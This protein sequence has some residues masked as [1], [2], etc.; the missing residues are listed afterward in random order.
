M[1]ASAGNYRHK[2]DIMVNDGTITYL[3]DD[4]QIIVLEEGAVAGTY[5]FNVDGKYLAA[6]SSSSN[7]LA[8]KDALD[9]NG[10]WTI[11][12]ADALATITAQG[13]KTRNILQYNASSPRFSCYKGTQEAVN[14]YAKSPMITTAIE[15]SVKDESEN[16]EV[17]YDLQGRRIKEITAPGI[18]IIG[19]KKVLVK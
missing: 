13:D 8:T 14:I 9:A 18:Y 10:S 2:T 3:A 1:G 19:G 5:A 4:V 7:Y 11:V 6:S 16:A 15:E 17:I 12:I